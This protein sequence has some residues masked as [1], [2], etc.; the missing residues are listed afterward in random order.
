MDKIEKAIDI[1]SKTWLLGTLFKVKRQ[2]FSSAFYEFIYLILW[3]LLPFALGGLILYAT[4]NDPQKSYLP[5]VISTIENG[6]LLVF[7]ISMLA[8]VLFLTWHDPERAEKFPHKLPISTISTIIIVT[9][10][11][12]IALQKASAVKDKDFIAEFSVV[13]TLIALGFRYLALVYHRYRLPSTNETELRKPQNDFVQNFEAHLEKSNTNK[14]MSF[15]Q[16]LE[17]RNGSNK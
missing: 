5:M 10:A 4:S 13:L 17:E 6:E 11:A 12:M 1:V 3:S 7:T 16:Q 9:C 15:K 8:P 2:A 14:A